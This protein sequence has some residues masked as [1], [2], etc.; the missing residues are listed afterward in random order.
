MFKKIFIIAI[1]PIIFY[2][3]NLLQLN[4]IIFMQ[5]KEIPL[6]SFLEGSGRKF[7][8]P[9]YQRDYSWVKSNCQ[10][11][12]DDI[13]LLSNSNRKDHFLGTVVGIVDNYS[14]Y[15]IIDGQQRL[16]TSSLLLLAFHNF[17]KNLPSKT[18][19][20]ISLENHL[21]EFLIDKHS[22]DGS[23]RIRLKP[24]LRDEIH[25]NKLF[26][27]PQNTKTD[28][29]SNILINYHFFLNKISDLAISRREFFNNFMKLKIIL[30]DLVRGNDDPQL[31]FESLN[32]TGVDLQS[33]DLIRNYILM[34]LPP[35]KQELF[36]KKYWLEIENYVD[37]GF[38]SFVQ[39]YLTLK[40]QIFIKSDDIYENF[41]KITLTKFNND[42]EKILEEMLYY[43][44]FFSIISQISKHENEKVNNNFKKIYDL[45]F[46]AADSYFM[47]LLADLDKGVL[48]IE[49]AINVIK[50]IECYIFRKI[51]VDNS[52][53]SFNKF[54]ATLSKDIKKHDNWQS[55]YFEILK[56]I[57]INRSGSTKFPT[58][59]DFE[60][61]LIYNEIYKSKNLFY[62]FENLENFNSPIQ[63][64]IDELEIEHIMPKTL[65]KDWQHKLGENYQ[66]I[67]KKY[68]NTLG[69][70]TLASSSQNKKL[71]NHSKEQKDKIDYQQSK[72]KLNYKL[73]ENSNW[74]ADSIVLRAKALARDAINIWQYPTT[75]F[76][77]N[78]I[79]DKIFDLS[80][81]ED[82]SGLRPVLIDIN[83]GKI[84]KEIKTWR[85]FLKEYCNYFYQNFPH[86]FD[87]ISKKDEIRKYFELKNMRTPLEFSKNK[88]VEANLSANMIFD[89]CQKICEYL[90]L[91]PENIKFKLKN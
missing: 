91:N 12:W 74:N 14:E 39:N 87:L 7:I 2:F 40:N 16:T 70:L 81:E 76:L 37:N 13:M 36:Y 59:E 41:K 89:L 64:K 28:L 18:H 75:S 25:F 10:K 21:L 84:A 52:S 24:N 47:E 50:L 66:E 78:K 82:F 9:V 61:A 42:K 86:E 29:S 31:I 56:Y 51:F 79:D 46:G 44:K 43:A 68:L 85:D 20:D 38:D 71:S 8:I 1:F 5:V 60:N 23:K 15:V 73:D 45:D 67:H 33:S 83:D 3:S 19:D 49:I 11:L 55:Q 6:F 57:L 22:S 26:D 32:S 17:I 35:E 72:L 69:N 27:N 30:I 4:S 48:N 34:D 80:C 62:L 77:E 90:K 54:F 58:D 65:S 63:I 88:F 53:K